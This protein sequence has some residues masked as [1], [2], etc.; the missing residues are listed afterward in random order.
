EEAV[1]TARGSKRP[2]LLL[3]SRSGDSIATLQSKVL[4]DDPEFGAFIH[5]NFVVATVGPTVDS[6]S[7]FDQSMENLLGGAELPPD[8]IELIV[9][10]D[11]QTPLFS[12]SGSQPAYRIISGLKR[13]LAARQV[14][15]HSEAARR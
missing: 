9:T 10:D 15:R 4:I 12:Q 1:A 11:G 14:A 6:G 8:A 3:V 7:Q 13:F 5:D 2:I